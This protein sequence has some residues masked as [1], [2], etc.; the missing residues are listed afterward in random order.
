MKPRVVAVA[1]VLLVAVLVSGG[2][3]SAADVSSGPAPTTIPLLDIAATTADV[4]IETAPGVSAS[5]DVDGSPSSAIAGSS[6][7]STTSEA[8]P[9]TT[10]TSSPTSTTADPNA[11]YCAAYN[12]LAAADTTIEPGDTE[13]TALVFAEREAAWRQTAAL[14]PA[15]ISTEALIVR[16]FVSVLRELLA[17]NGNDLA[18]VLSEAT[19]L[20]AD[21]GAE[22]AQVLVEQFG[23][24]ACGTET[25]APEEETAVF[26]AGLL[27]TPDRRSVLAELLS[28]DFVLSADEA[29]CFVAQATAEMMFPLTGAPSTPDQVAA[30]GQLL[31]VC[32][33]SAGGS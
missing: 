5:P 9:A 20:E 26:Y 13:A 29:D 18:A 11:E 33:L 10:A 24:L 3:S 31:G 21:L 14:A 22:V 32:Q 28:T 8:P 27:D 16:D 2:C 23:L 15:S 17:E 30:L 12:A 6:S 4:V 25:S 19:A 1:V 7:S